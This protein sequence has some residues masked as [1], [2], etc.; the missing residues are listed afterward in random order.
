[1]LSPLRAYFKRH[2]PPQPEEQHTSAL[3]QELIDNAPDDFFTMHWLVETIPNRSFGVVILFLGLFAMIPIIGIT[4][5]LMIIFLMVEILVGYRNPAL[6]RSWMKKPLPS[7][8]LLRLERHAIPFLK[9]VEKSVRPR[10]PFLLQTRR[11][12]ASLALLITLI[13]L[14]APVPFSNIPPSAVILL[15]ALAYIEHD[16][17]LLMIAHISAIVLILLTVLAILGATGTHVFG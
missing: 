8:H 6:P 5:R 2:Y 9:R 13:S 4:A 16:G 11:L 7:K 1:M 17:L 15:M 14:L 12:S 10:W 3:L